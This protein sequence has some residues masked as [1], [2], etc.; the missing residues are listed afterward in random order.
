M[1]KK[2]SILAKLLLIGAG[3]LAVVA[4]PILF[5]FAPH[6]ATYFAWAIK[7]PMTPA[8]MGA[9]YF[10]GIGALWA[11]R[12]NRWSVARV[13][14]PGIFTFAVTQLFAT[15]LGYQIF[16]WHRVI[17]WAWL[18]VY[19]GSPGATLLVYFLMQRGYQAP[20]FDPRSVP[21][22]FRPVMLLFSLFSA[23]VGFL[24]W[25]WPY[26]LSSLIAGSA[27]PWWGWNLTPLTAHVVGGWFFAAAALYATLSR[28]H[29]PQAVRIALIGVIAATGLEVLGAIIYRGA[30]N[31]PALTAWLYVLNAASVCAFGVFTRLRTRVGAPASLAPGPA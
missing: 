1:D 2:L 9:N 27:V 26:N 29:P 10:G 15:V 7:N 14:M 17:A 3:G 22:I 30:I 21:G 12:A 19:I 23:L 4:G 31:G 25:F 6:T 18:F 28:P 5:I 24:L 13:L 8:F 20:D 11:V 16:L